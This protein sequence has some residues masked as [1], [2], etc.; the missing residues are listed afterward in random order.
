[1]PLRENDLIDTMFK[2]ISIDEFQPKTGDT[3][4]VV[5]LGFY[6]NFCRSYD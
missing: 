6:L 2:E 4:D 3:K 1:M 5:V